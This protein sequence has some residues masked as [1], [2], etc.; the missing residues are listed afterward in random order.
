MQ[1]KFQLSSAHPPDAFAIALSVVQARSPGRRY[2]PLPSQSWHQEEE[3]YQEATLVRSK[4]LPKK[5]LQ[6]GQYPD[7]HLGSI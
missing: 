1:T 6:W 5:A 3:P 7:R 2:I 4:P